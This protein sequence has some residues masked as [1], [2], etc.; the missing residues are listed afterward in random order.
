MRCARIRPDEELGDRCRVVRRV[1]AGV[2]A[3]R[4]GMYYPVRW[5]PFFKQFMTLADIYHYRP[6]P[7]SPGPGPSRQHPGLVQVGQ[8]TGGILSSPSCVYI[9]QLSHVPG[10]R[11]S[12]EETL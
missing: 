11:M 7:P 4:R 2:G 5:D 9:F 8:V 12:T 3:L 10:S 1:L 6:P